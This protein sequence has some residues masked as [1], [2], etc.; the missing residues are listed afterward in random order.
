VVDAETGE[1]LVGAVLRVVELALSDVAHADG[2]L[3]FGPVP[4]GSWTVSASRLGYRTATRI[5]QV[6]PGE[7]VDVELRLTPSPLSVDGITVTA[8]SRL[9]RTSDALRPVAVLS[10]RELNETL[11]GTLAGSLQGQPG[12]ATAS[13]GPATARP[14]IRGLGGDRV[15]ILEDGERTGDLSAASGDHA[16]AVEPLN[17]RQIEVVRGPAA[18]LYGSNALG[19]VVNVVREDIP[20]QLPDHLAGRVTAEA[21]TVNRGGALGGAVT[22]SLGTGMALRGEVSARTAGDLQTPSGALDNTDLETLTLS[23]GGSWIGDGAYAGGAYRYYRNHYGL[24]GGFV[25]AHPNGVRIEMRRHQGR[26]RGEIREPLGGVE[27]LEASATYTRYSHEEIESNGSVGTA[28]RTLTSTGEVQARVRP[29]GPLGR[30]TLG[31][32]LQHEDHDFGGLLDTENTRR[33]SLGAY[34]VQEWQR[35]PFE[36]EGGLRYDRWWA[37]PDR[38]RP[39]AEIGSIRDRSFGAVSGSVGVLTRLGGGVSLGASVS[40]AFRTPDVNELFSLGPHL[41]AYS[42]EVGNPALGEETGLGLDLVARVERSGIRAEVAVYRNDLS[43]YVFPRNTGELSVTGLPVYQFTGA[44]AL[45]A[46]AEGRAELQLL[47]TL[48][49]DAAASW[50]R[51]TLTDTDQPLPFIPPARGSVGIRWED[52]SWLGSLGLRAAAEQDRVGEFETPTAGYA[53]VDASVGYRVVLGGRLH[54]FLLRGSNL[55]DQAYR[56]HLS[57][58]KEIM[59]EAGRGVSLLYRVSF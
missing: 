58:T 2:S 49:L 55:L 31:V 10:A 47:P 38:T 33:T 15:L 34:L 16:V 48:A 46:G 18:L 1:A 37:T 29:W 44:D 7:T 24:P 14:V 5:V 23:A 13:M 57:R 53:V 11:T 59:P 17:A 8:S 36:V 43:G 6:D 42:F 40:R 45:L 22:G 21:N 56:D 51:G 25:G 30:G 39:D 26:A 35:G 12:V 20:N 54:S 32:R 41:A 52:R 19:G 3:H 9:R 27:S 4:P 28:F 50:V